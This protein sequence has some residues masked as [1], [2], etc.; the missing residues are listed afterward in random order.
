VPR[1][2]V[3]TLYACLVLV[4]SST[5]VAIKIGLEDVPPLVG[6][7]V[8]FAIAGAGLLVVARLPFGALAFG[9]ALYDEPITVIAVS[10]ALLVASGLLI[11]KWPRRRAIGAT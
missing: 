3:W 6:A 10:G 8:R 4:W 11:A 5:W 9:A 1:T 7:G 2:L